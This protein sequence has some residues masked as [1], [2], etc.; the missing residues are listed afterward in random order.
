MGIDITPWIAGET[1]VVPV[2]ARLTGLRALL[3]RLVEELEQLSFP[4]GDPDP[5]EQRARQDRALRLATAAL[6]LAPPV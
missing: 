6:E 1:A 3:E 2:E 5:D 4:A